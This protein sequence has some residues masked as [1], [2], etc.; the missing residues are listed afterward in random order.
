MTRLAVLLVALL[1][2]SIGARAQDCIASA[3]APDAV[4]TAAPFNAA[5]GA[6][7]KIMTHLR[8]LGCK[9]EVS[10]QLSA[11]PAQPALKNM[12]VLGQKA[13][14]EWA[15]AVVEDPAQRE[16]FR[17]SVM[18]SELHTSPGCRI[19]GRVSG[20]TEIGGFGLVVTDMQAECQQPPTPLSAEF[21]SGYDGQCMYQVQ[22][23][24][25]PGLVPL[26]PEG[27][28]AVLALFKS[29]RFGR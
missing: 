27:R 21:Y 9:P 11:G 2:W 8:C 19:E 25:G 22:L 28:S 20:V 3:Q 10:M 18:R 14:I 4:W 23:V 13:G 1:V 17:E 24:W 26:S 16:G 29:L 15:R 6:P 5:G 12:P 7:L